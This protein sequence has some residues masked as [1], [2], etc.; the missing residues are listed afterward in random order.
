MWL[1]ADPAVRARRRH[2]ERDGLG[3]EELAAELRRRDERDAVNTHRA[4]DAVE[5]DTTDLTL[6]EVVGRIASLVEARAVSLPDVT[7]A[8]GRPTIGGAA[9]LASRLQGVRD[10]SRAARRRARRRRRTTSTGSTPPSLGAAQPA[11]H[12]LHGEDRGAPRARVRRVHPDASAASPSG[13]GSPTARRCARCGGSCPR[14]TRS[15]CSSRARAS[16]RACPGEVQPGAAMVAIQESVPIVPVAI[17]GSQYWKPGNLQ[18]R[19]DR[20]GRADDASTGCRRAARATRRRRVLLQAEIRRL[21]D[22]LVEVHEL[23]RPAAF[24]LRRTPLDHGRRSPEAL[25][26]AKRSEAPARSRS[27]ASRTSASRR[28]ST[29]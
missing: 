20:V 1:V 11:G 26:T 15:A 6:D 4:D 13:G 14:G 21:W 7:W 17:H 22:W 9:T 19:V 12:L 3:M 25:L 10:G 27:S 16:G 8:L 23:G 5:I 29:G 18:A 2:L 24:R 28:S